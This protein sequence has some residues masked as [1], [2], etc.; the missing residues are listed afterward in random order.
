[1]AKENADTTVT[2]N[3]LKQIVPEWNKVSTYFVIIVMAWAGFTIVSG[4]E[5]PK[6]KEVHKRIESGLSDPD[7]G[8]GGEVHVLRGTAGERAFAG[9]C[10]SVQAKGVDFRQFAGARL[11]CERVTPVALHHKA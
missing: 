11:G 7:D 10:G 8:C 4:F 1:M 9:M 3:F 2:V 5:T 6:E